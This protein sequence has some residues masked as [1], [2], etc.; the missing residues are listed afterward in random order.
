MI[1]YRVFAKFFDIASKIMCQECKNFIKKGEK[2]LDLGC[3]CGI[4]GKNFR[5][6]F[7]A[8]VIG[9]DIKDQRVAKIPFQVMDGKNLP[10]QDNSFNTVLIAY[11]LHHAEEPM[12]L[13]KEAKRVTNNKI[14][15]FEDLSEGF[16]ADMVCR[17][18][19]ISF[20][21]YFQKNGQKG[22]FLD[23]GG[24]KKIFSALGLRLI[25]EKRAININIFNP[26]KKKLF[27]LEKGA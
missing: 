27:V 1:F 7:Q 19:G 12:A 3:G 16:L 24:W 4:A 18:H 5:D 2:I 26:V 15:I 22:K 21:Y 17:I 10:F 25:F 23:E 6:F 9:A 14:I 11:V 13:L 20:N 8:E